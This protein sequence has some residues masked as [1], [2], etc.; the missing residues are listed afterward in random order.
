M[1]VSLI[2]HHVHLVWKLGICANQSLGCS[3]SALRFARRHSHSKI[4]SIPDM[5]IKPLKHPFASSCVKGLLPVF[6]LGTVEAATH[7][8]FLHVFGPITL[9]GFINPSHCE[10]YPVCNALVFF[11]MLASLPESFISN[12]L[13]QHVF[14]YLLLLTVVLFSL[15]SAKDNEG[16]QVHIKGILPSHSLQHC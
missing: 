15:L 10:C 5:L 3:P 1:C 14:V 13:I 11:L 16:Q 4:V 8:T 12:F 9:H 7:C 6:T 2:Y